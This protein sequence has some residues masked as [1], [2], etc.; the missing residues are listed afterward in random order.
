MITSFSR[1]GRMS[2]RSVRRLVT[3]VAS[4][5]AL[6]LPLA[7]IAPAVPASAATANHAATANNVPTSQAL[8]AMRAEAAKANAQLAAGAKKLDAARAQLSA[9]QAKAAA[10]KAAASK[11]DAKLAGVQAQLKVYASDIYEHPQA[12]AMSAIIS[13]D[14]RLSASLQANDLLGFVNRGRTE[15]LRQVSIDSQQAKVLRA[16]ADQANAAAAAIQKSVSAQVSA[17]QAQATKV[18]KQL[19]A[20]Q[21]AYDAEQA[22]LAAERAAAVKAARD[23]AA[24]AAARAEAERQARARQQSVQPPSD[25][26]P[27]SYPSGPWGGYSD[28]LIPASQLCAIIGGGMLRPDAAVAFNR[29]TQAYAQAFG[30]PLCINASYRP[31]ADQVRLFR[32]EP[33]FAAVPGTS[34]HGWGLAVD[35]G[36]GVQNFG[37][38]QY[39]WMVANAGRYGFVHPGWATRNPFEPWH[40][41][42]GHPGGSGGQ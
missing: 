13:A 19:S 18:S 17:L 10:A 12:S 34:N 37:S 1:A 28:G 25:C 16:K 14:G 36:C 40:W 22:R 4:S 20:A 41:E 31:Y 32:Q 30:S 24:R 33:G 42:F 21:A 15:V 38:P 7:V 6:A 35:L 39:R 2:Q 5:A 27:G 26:H 9:Q 8:A 11:V 23:A 29:M 3:A